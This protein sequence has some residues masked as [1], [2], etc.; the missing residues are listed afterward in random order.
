[1]TITGISAL[2]RSRISPS[3]PDRSFAFCVS[4][5]GPLR[6]LARP[7]RRG[8]EPGLQRS[9]SPVWLVAPASIVLPW[10]SSPWPRQAAR[11]VG[12]LAARL[13]L[14]PGQL[15]RARGELAIRGG[16]IAAG[17]VDLLGRVAHAG[18]GVRDEPGAR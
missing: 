17:L 3:A 1:L 12:G 2:T 18:G 14:G 15:A 8:G 13:A 6:E 4:V 7:V 9:T 16:E 11:D 10:L 5:R